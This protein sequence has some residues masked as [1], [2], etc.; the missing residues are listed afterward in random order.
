MAGWRKCCC[1][2][3]IIFQDDFTR[4]AGTPLGL[5]TSAPFEGKGW[6]DDPGDYYIVA[7]PTY[8]ARCEV[9]NS[10]AI[11][12]VKHPDD[13][14][15]MS[16]LF[17]TA[18]ELPRTASYSGGGQKYRIILN[19]TKTSSGDPEVCTSEN[20]Y[21][22]EYERLGGSVLPADQ[23]W[24]RLGVV[25]AGVETIIKQ[26]Q[27]VV[28]EAGLSRGFRAEID[29]NIF[30]AR[31]GGVVLGGSISI[32]S[33]GLHANGFYCGF[34]LSEKDMLIDDFVF[35]RHFNSNPPRTRE[36]NCPRCST[37]DCIDNVEYNDE[38]VQLPSV[39]NV[40]VFTEE[41]CERLIQLV[42]CSF[43]LTYD[44]VDGVWATDSFHCC[45]GFRFRFSCT[46][47]YGIEKYR[48][49]N[50]GGCVQSGGDSPNR[51]PIEYE[52]NHAANTGR[53]LFGPYCIA[54]SD[55]ACACR[56]V[57]DMFDPACCYY[58]EVTT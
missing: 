32:E 15:S 1:V 27:I 47:Q 31:I 46:S 23:S 33:P 10:L 38:F 7:S 48:L 22:A 40:R 20:Y 9:P 37:C 8:R 12:N 3:C 55:F 44:D 45:G 6:C 30:C 4:A 39:L 21:F 5:R 50:I 56:P 34:S 54:G 53:W 49:A 16:V 36:L 2:E 35:Q 51:A 18:N 26:K 52:C 24:L 17:W 43:Q 19:A 29:E 41:S 42:N 13:V 58:V 25:T 57:L 11:C 14:G 28:G